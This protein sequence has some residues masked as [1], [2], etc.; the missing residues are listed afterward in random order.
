MPER[1][2]IDIERVL[3]HLG[4]IKLAYSVDD[5]AND[6]PISRF[7]WYKAIDSGRL[8]ALKE[9]DKTLILLWDLIAYFE[10]LPAYKSAPG[11]DKRVK[12]AQALRS[13]RGK[14]SHV[15]LPEGGPADNKCAP[16]L[17]GAAVSLTPASDPN[18]EEKEVGIAR[19]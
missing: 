6:T 12:Q 15:V 10:S 4:A 7:G 11:K 8:V 19:S 14:A 9:G 3:A 2:K 5:L 16:A 13:L 18:G 17:S 1:I